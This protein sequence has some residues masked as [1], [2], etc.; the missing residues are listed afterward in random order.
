ML[1]HEKGGDMVNVPL[2]KKKMC[3]LARLGE[4]PLHQTIKMT[5]GGAFLRSKT[6]FPPFQ[7]PYPRDWWICSPR[8]ILFRI[9][10][11]RFALLPF[12][13]SAI[14][15]VMFFR[16]TILDLGT[17]VNAFWECHTLSFVLFLFLVAHM[18]FCWSRFGYRIL[19]CYLSCDV[20][21]SIFLCC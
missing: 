20:A 2:K 19:V 9:F 3:R 16:E 17:C 13:I 12:V 7:K 21:F 4:P 11:F 6:S 10:W 8:V 1:I 14:L 15:V 18:F 5:K